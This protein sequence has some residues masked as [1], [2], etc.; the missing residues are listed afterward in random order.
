[1][2]ISVK[3]GSGVKK[4]A[5][6]KDILYIK[7]G[8]NGTGFV[9]KN[10]LFNQDVSGFHVEVVAVWNPVSVVNG[11]TVVSKD[12]ITQVARFDDEQVTKVATSNTNFTASV[13][14]QGH[15][16]LTLYV[17]FVTDAGVVIESAP[18]TVN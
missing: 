1:M 12:T 10:Y 3:S 16:N 11:E 15:E 6:G 17:R 8:I 13:A 7:F 18:L 5:E 4:D 14:L 9:K 2:A